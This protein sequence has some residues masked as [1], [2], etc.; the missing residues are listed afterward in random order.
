MAS[1]SC[2]VSMI[3]TATTVTSPNAAIN[4]KIAKVFRV[5]ISINYP[6]K[7]FPWLALT[8]RLFLHPLVGGGAAS[9]SCIVRITSI[10]TTVTKP[11]AA[12]SANSTIAVWVSIDQ[13]YFVKYMNMIGNIPK[14]GQT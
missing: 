2:A 8:A 11:S 5:I 6:R 14:S 13:K 7:H 1:A 12:T 3:S 10:A 9:I 4:A